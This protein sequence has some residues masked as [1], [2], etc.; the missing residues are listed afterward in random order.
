MAF[1]K[2]KTGLRRAAAVGM[3]MMMLFGLFGCGR[4]GTP[5]EAAARYLQRKY[6]ESFELGPLTQKGGGPFAQPTFSG[7]ACPQDDPLSAFTVWVS[8]DLRTVTDARGATALLPA[9]NDR[10]QTE[11]RKLWPEAAA[12]VQLI[13]LTYDDSAHYGDDYLR[14]FQNETA[15]AAVLLAL[16]AGT[17]PTEAYPLFDAA[18]R[19]WMTGEVRLYFVSGAPDLQT[20]LTQTPALSVQI[21]AA[22][23]VM[24]DKLQSLQED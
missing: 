17:D 11:A 13:A 7:I 22:P 14:F 6:G 12:A 2:C 4:P 20:L 23:R 19:D 5:E 24:Q 3:V 21:G 1:L 9:L 18:L 8:G 16:P 15:S 10:V